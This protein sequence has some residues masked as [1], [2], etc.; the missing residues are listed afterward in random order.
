MELGKHSKDFQ[1]EK[2][3]TL[4]NR[5]ASPSKMP[6]SSE[7]ENISRSQYVDTGREESSARCLED[8]RLNVWTPQRSSKEPTSHLGIRTSPLK[9]TLEEDPDVLLHALLMVP[10]GKNFSGGPLQAPNVYLNCKLFWCDETARSVVSWGQ[11]NPT[12]NF[13]QV[14]FCS[15]SEI[16]YILIYKGIHRKLPQ[17]L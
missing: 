7:R 13:V 17:C 5:D 15:H 3:K 1:S 8:S 12:F 11:R 10:D 14:S 16:Q 4:P 2:N 6:P 9:S